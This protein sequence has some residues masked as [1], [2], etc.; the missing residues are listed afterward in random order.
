MEH[1]ER[2][3]KFVVEVQAEAD[4]APHLILAFTEACGVMGFPAKAHQVP[5]D[6]PGWR[7]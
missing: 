7:S 5:D 1:M 6:D 2:W 4:E 3:L